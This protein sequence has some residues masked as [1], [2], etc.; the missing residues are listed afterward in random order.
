MLLL[1]QAVRLVIVHRQRVTPGL[2]DIH[3]V[4][5]LESLFISLG[6]RQPATAPYCDALCARVKESATILYEFLQIFANIRARRDR[7]AAA[8]P[9]FDPCAPPTSALCYG[10]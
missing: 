3:N 2:R 1:Q 8:T 4:L 7:N 6:R 5:R 10:S 9:N